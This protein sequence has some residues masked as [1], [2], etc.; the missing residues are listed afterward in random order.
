M[1][2]SLDQPSLFYRARNS[3]F[4]H[5]VWPIRSHELL[6][7]VPMALLMF[8]ILLN[9]NL[10][11]AFKDSLVVTSIG[12]E[13]LSFIKLWCEAPCAVLFIIIYTKLCNIMT[14]E[15]VFRIVVSSFLIFF[16]FFAYVLFPYR[17]Y[18]HP[19]PEAVKEYIQLFP[20]LKWFLVIWSKWGFVLFYIAGEL[21]PIVVFTLL[22]WQLANKITK[23]EEA[24]RFYPFF[25]LFGQTNLLFSGALVIYFSKGDH[26]LLPLF[27]HLTDKTEIMLKSFLVIIVISGLICL[28][29]QRFIEAQIIET[30]KNIKFKNQRTDILKLGIVDSA[31]MV[32]SSRYLGAICILMISYSMSIA[33]IEGLWMSKT[34]QLY[35]DTH[36]FMSYQGYVFFWTGIFTLVCSFCGSTLIRTCGW[37]AGAI[38]T[39]IM[40]GLAGSLFFTFVLLQDHISGLFIG[41]TAASP[42]MVIVFMGGLQNVL[43]KGTKYSLFDSTKE[44]V[45]I[46]LDSEMKTKGKAAVDL[47]GYKI[48]K[49]SGSV[50]QF[51]TFTMFP[52]VLH[53][54]I[55]GFL[56]IAFIMVCIVWIFG[57]KSLSKHYY[58]FLGK[59]KLG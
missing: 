21:W 17:D 1:I 37:F 24:S 16:I 44:M 42:L 38:M 7:F 18:F 32:F 40:I 43:G 26:F 22:Y 12:T 20:H 36:D 15:K 6:K 58:K 9:Q 49:S 54:D 4:R 41:I 23:T 5:I 55:A 30:D 28:A 14:T 59:S 51:V 27:S 33:L 45:Y 3:K 10:V 19:D 53:N 52:N 47:L 46:P 13:V 34:R 31:K 35:P 48:G 50:V 29:L 57:V 2:Q 56:M 25:N 39:P 11:R 8:F